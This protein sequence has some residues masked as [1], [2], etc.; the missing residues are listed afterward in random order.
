MSQYIIAL[1]EGTTSARTIL[2]D[3]CANRLSIGQKEFTQYYPKPG[4]V[5]HNP[6]EIWQAQLQSY[7]EALNKA[8]ITSNKIACIGITNQ[9][10]TTLVWDKRSG[11][12]I[13]NAI[14]W[15]CRRTAEM[16]TEFKKEHGV[17]IKEKTGLVLDSYFSAPK[18]KWILE[19]VPGA[20][21]RAEKGDLLFGTI[22]SY[23]IYKLTSEEIHATDPS[24]ASRTLL[25]NIYKEEWDPEL[26][27]LFNI[28]DKMLPD[29]VPSSGLVGYTSS[30]LLGASIPISG[31][32]GNQQ[33]ALF[34]HGAFEKGDSKCTYGT[35]NFMLMN[36]GNQPVRSETLLTTI[37]WHINNQ[38]TYT[39]EGSIFTTGAAIQWLRE[40]LQIISSSEESEILAKSVSDNGGVYMVPA[41]TGLGAPHWDQEARGI[42]TGL[43]RGTTRAHI[44]R[45]ALESVAY[46]T[47]DLINTMQ[48]DSNHSINSLIVDGGATKNRFLLQFQADILNIPILRPESVETTARGIALLAGLGIGIWS[49]KEEFTSL[50]SENEIFTPKMDPKTR[51]KLLDGWSNALKRA[52]S[53]NH[54]MEY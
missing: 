1:D 45:A 54:L 18:I 25:Y 43:T 48:K 2:H 6:E 19:K 27:E 42:I 30:N 3:E 36:T 39:L 53:D 5:E 52:F 29:V 40:G 28:P 44:T 32:A 21:E 51:S 24:N 4:W 14:C 37:G 23:L 13:Y 50:E 17:A 8:E 38:T 33:S 10:E 22:D 7:K 20:R 16:V 31:C 11:F 34:G 47:Y 49:N 9:R 15:Q 41:F 12:P 35:G 26:L 46:Q